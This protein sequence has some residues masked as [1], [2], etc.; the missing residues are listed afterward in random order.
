MA[1]MLRR[2]RGVGALLRRRIAEPGESRRRCFPACTA[3]TAVRS[4]QASGLYLVWSHDLDSFADWL[5]S[6]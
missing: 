4:A 1:G 3:S 6:Q 5:A 2:E